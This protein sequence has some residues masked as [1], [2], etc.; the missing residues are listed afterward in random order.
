MAMYNDGMNKSL[1]KIDKTI[2]SGKMANK[3]QW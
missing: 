3:L 2:N 1:K